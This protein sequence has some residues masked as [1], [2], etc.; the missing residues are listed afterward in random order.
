MNKDSCTNKV[1]YIYK[2]TYQ[3]SNLDSLAIC[4]NIN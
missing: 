3:E 4:T 1:G 2:T